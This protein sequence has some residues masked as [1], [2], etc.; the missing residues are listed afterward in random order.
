MKN[1]L[2]TLYIFLLILVQGCTFKIKMRERYFTQNELAEYA[3]AKKYPFDFILHFK[4]VANFKS[5]HEN[6]IN[7]INFMNFYSKNNYLIKSSD[8]E[9]CEFKI[10]SF[11]KD[12]LDKFVEN[13][14]ERYSLRAICGKSE[15]IA[16]SNRGEVLADSCYKIV[17]GWSIMLNNFG[18]IKNRLDKLFQEI[19]LEDK[20]FIIVGMNLDPIKDQ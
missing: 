19:D 6:N 3:K 9:N 1:T 11:I 2:I 20:K 17:I 15:I 14:N 18:M 7:S 10:A 16:L 5:R 4:N 12:S 8:G 13:K